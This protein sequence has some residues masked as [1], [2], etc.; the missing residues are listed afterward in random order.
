MSISIIAVEGKNGELGKGNSL[1]WDL[2]LDMKHFKNTT[3][4]KTI[5]MGQKTFESIG[6]PLPNRRNIVMTRNPDWKA[7]GVEISRSKEDTIKLLGKEE[8][9][10]IGGGQIYKLFLENA[11]KLYITRVEGEFPEADTFFP[12]IDPLKW[13]IVKEEKH[14]KDNEHSFDF[15]FRVYERI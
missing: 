2:P 12:K 1:L 14:R 6:K 5:I 4:G 7:E 9:F 10:V 15:S 13:K 8:S 11:D 3:S